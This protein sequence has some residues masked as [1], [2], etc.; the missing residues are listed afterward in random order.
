MEMR[1]EGGKA[2]QG[3]EGCV[4]L[5]LLRLP[6]IYLWETKNC[7]NNNKLQQSPWGNCAIASVKSNIIQLIRKETSVMMCLFHSR[8]F[9]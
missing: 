8:M 7:L 1:K 3:R 2:E 6:L 9:D 4:N 5:R